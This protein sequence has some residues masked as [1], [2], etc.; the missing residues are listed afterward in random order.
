[1][2]VTGGTDR[3][4]ID[5]C[6]GKLQYG[7]LLDLLSTV[8]LSIC[9]FT[10][11]PASF[12]DDLA[13]YAGAGAAG[14]GVLEGKLDDDARGKLRAS[15]LRAT[16]CVPAVPSILPLPSIPGPAEPE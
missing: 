16:H 10:T 8:R 15:G 14:I 4:N 1:D 5:R 2:D 12:E 7:D 9:E 13:A 3:D 6:P 11:L